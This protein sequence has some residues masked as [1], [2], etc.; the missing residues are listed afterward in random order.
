MLCDSP[1]TPRATSNSVLKLWHFWSCEECQPY[2]SSW[3][4]SLQRQQVEDKTRHVEDKSFSEK[5]FTMSPIHLNLW[6]L[7]AKTIKNLSSGIW[8]SHLRDKVLSLG[9]EM[10]ICWSSLRQIWDID[11]YSK[12]KWV[13]F[14][15]S[16]PLISSRFNFSSCSQE[17]ETHSPKELWR[18]PTD[19]TDKTRRK[20]NLEKGLSRITSLQIRL[21]LQLK[22]A[23]GV[24]NILSSKETWISSSCPEHCNALRSQASIWLPSEFGSKH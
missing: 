14:S 6:R 2:Q 18:N 10:C 9:H 13:R 4:P 23:K 7:G 3:Y 19:F 15:L 1:T 8:K 22:L 20:M 21:K 12:H 17:Y 11:K 24:W 5:P 16:L